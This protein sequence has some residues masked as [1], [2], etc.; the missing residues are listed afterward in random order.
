MVQWLRTCK[1]LSKGVE[2]LVLATM[3]GGLQLAVTPAHLASVGIRL[4][5]QHLKGRH[6]HISEFEASLVYRLSSRT[7][8]ATKRKPVLKQQPQKPYQTNKKNNKGKN[9]KDC[10]GNNLI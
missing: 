1:T 10:S 3:S 2:F 5:S 7:A 6:R 4:E 8:R 9:S